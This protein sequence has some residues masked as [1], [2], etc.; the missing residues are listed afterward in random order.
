MLKFLLRGKPK[1]KRAEKRAV[2][3]EL[4]AIDGADVT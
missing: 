3:R 1:A 4:L 2:R